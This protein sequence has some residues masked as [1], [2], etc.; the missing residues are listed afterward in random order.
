[1][2]L[3]QWQELEQA[4]CVGDQVERD[5]C[6]SISAATR[7]R[8]DVEATRQSRIDDLSMLATLAGHCL[9]VMRRPIR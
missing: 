7:A 1:M 8:I 6:R 9:P 3:A 2:N 4:G 5:N